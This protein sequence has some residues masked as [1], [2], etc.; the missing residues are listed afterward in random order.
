MPDPRSPSPPAPAVDPPGTFVPWRDG[1]K[2]G[3]VV[4]G[5]GCHVWTGARISSGYGTVSIDGRTHLVHRV[6]YEREVGPIPDSLVVDHWA[7]DNGPRGCCNPHHCRPVTRRENNLRSESRAAVLAAR[8]HC[9]RGHPLSGKNLRPALLAR[10]IRKCAECERQRDRARQPA[11]TQR[12]KA[13]TDFGSARKLVRGALDRL[14]LAISNARLGVVTSPQREVIADMLR[15]A[16]DL[17]D[18][19]LS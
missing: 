13:H 10:G 12:K 14:E 19:E 11:R 2:Y 16:A 9:P 15:E 8:T 7:C 18:P 5:S 17:L 6:R 4:A 1:A 3:W